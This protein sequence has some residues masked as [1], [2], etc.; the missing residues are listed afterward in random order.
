MVEDNTSLQEAGEE[1]KI[2]SSGHRQSSV[3]KMRKLSQ[4][5]ISLHEALAALRFGVLVGSPLF[6]SEYHDIIP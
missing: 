5:L 6:V 3:N 1:I 2:G 4:L